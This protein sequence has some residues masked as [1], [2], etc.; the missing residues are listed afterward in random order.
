VLLEKGSIKFQDG[1][2]FTLTNDADSELNRNWAHLWHWVNDPANKAYA[3]ALLEL[4][5]TL[6]LTYNTTDE[7]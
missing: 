2:T 6:N 5:S 3:A 4:A 7:Q 1:P